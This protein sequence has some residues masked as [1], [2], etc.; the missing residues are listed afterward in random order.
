MAV[1]VVLWRIWKSRNWVVFEGKQFGFESLMR[2]FHQQC[3]EWER[4]QAIPSPPLAVTVPQHLPVPQEGSGVV[5][6]WD[7][8][9][10]TVSHAAGGMVVL[11]SG[12]GV[13]LAKGIQFLSIEDPVVAEVLA[14][15]EA[16][17]WC[18]AR[19]FGEVC[20]EGDA[21]VIIDKVRRREA[22][23]SRM[24][25]VLSEVVQLFVAH[26]GLSIRFVGR[27]SNRVAHLVARKAISLYPTACS[28]FDF[29]A[30][31]LSRM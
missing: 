12:D 22:E 5:C 17:R 19:G 21:K 14:L 18:I 25:A 10:R 4:A 28:V 16:V 11:C 3:D 9:T 8:A 24:G 1:I 23:D 31:L 20:F 30:C 7:G 6:R 29:Q 13:L 2:Q 15:R 26:P 27:R